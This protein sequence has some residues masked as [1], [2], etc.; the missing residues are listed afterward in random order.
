MDISATANPLPII[1]AIETSCD[2]T[3]ISLVKGLEVISHGVHSQANLHAEFGGVFPTLAKREHTRNLTPLL[4]HVFSE[5]LNHDFTDSSLIIKNE[6][7]D[8]RT[9]STIDQL[10]TETIDH[11]EQLLS[12]EEG[13][14]DS[15]IDYI[16]KLPAEDFLRIKNNLSGI[17]VTYGPGLEPAL[18]V[19][20]S[21]AKALS[22]IFNIPLYP[23][24]HMEGHI[25]SVLSSHISEVEFPALGLLISGGHTELVEIS[26][27]HQY[28]ILG[29]T[30][31][32]AVGEAYDKA[33]RVL[34][35]PYP[36]GPEISKLA[37]AY[38][39][40]HP[41]HGNNRSVHQ[42][43]ENTFTLPRP[44]IHSHDLN[45][46]FS[47]LKTAVLYTVRDHKAQH[48][49]RDLTEQEKMALSAEFESAVCEVLIKKTSKAIEEIGAKTLII[50]G[51]VISNT[52][53]REKFTKL[54]EELHLTL[55]IPE[56]NLATDNA[57]MIANVAYLRI[58]SG[59]FGLMPG[60]PQFSELKAE[61]NLS[62]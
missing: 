31:D 14:A 61:G 29:H 39:Q 50:G 27:W 30:V 28:Q 24:N 17:A 35:L 53:L 60:S 18:W 15:L 25:A 44:M 36:G 23:I 16:S 33:A 4:A 22:V 59:E 57:T 21:F 46:S 13:L 32:D 51:G 7:V 12:R 55:L 19:G 6:S 47:G 5:F 42:K 49:N 38:R 3:A 43:N 8:P 26:S 54:S 62:L 9:T 48:N 58:I 11:I 2:E 34:G 37:E 40:S 56:K 1:L 45:F 41:E 20:I 52:F 10:S